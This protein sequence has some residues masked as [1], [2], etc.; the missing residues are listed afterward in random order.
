MA[1][2]SYVKTLLGALPANV[3]GPVG[4]A[5]EYVLVNLRMGRATT[6]RRAENLQL[7]AIEGTTHATP[8]TEFSV[9][10][11]LGT[12]PYLLIPVLRL[13]DVNSEVVPLKVTRVPDAERV[14]LSS[15]V[16]SAPFVALVEAG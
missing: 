4:D 14:Y 5:F 13:T 2:S 7:Y 15:S 10:H 6:G 11:G 8:D 1:N 16:A 12:A 9:T 3:K